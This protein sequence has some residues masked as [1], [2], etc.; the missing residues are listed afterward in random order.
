MNNRMKHLKH[1][2]YPTQILCTITVFLLLLSGCNAAGGEDSSSWFNPP[3]ETTIVLYARDKMIELRG[4]ERK[5]LITVAQGLAAPAGATETDLDTVK[6]QLQATSDLIVFSET[7]GTYLFVDRALAK[8]Y[9]YQPFE[10]TGLTAYDYTYEITDSFLTTLD[11]LLADN[12]PVREENTQ[13]KI[14]SLLESK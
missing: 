3:G 5:K 4:D 13:A 10:H 2:K 7:Q 11:G 12:P 9:F 8:A 14:M 1:L 6:A